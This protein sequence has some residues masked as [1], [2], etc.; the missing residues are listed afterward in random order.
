ML[1]LEIR[2]SFEDTAKMAADAIIKSIEN[3]SSRQQ[4]IKQQF[5]MC[6]VN[7]S[8]FNPKDMLSGGVWISPSGDIFGVSLTHIRAVIDNPDKFGLSVE[9]IKAVF[10]KHGEG[11]GSEGEARDEIISLLIS[12]GWV[13][14]RYYPGEYF[15]VELNRLT[16]SNKYFLFSWSSKILSKYPEKKS[17]QVVI[18]ERQ[19]YPSN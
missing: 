4:S 17:F 16:R 1:R 7:E 14:I 12:N 2:I 19:K 5:P 8:F 11:I 15:H 3:M 6:S 18:C 13:R 9:Y 10:N